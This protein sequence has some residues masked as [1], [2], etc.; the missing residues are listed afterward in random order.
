MASGQHTATSSALVLEAQARTPPESPAPLL[1]TIF[2]VSVAVLLLTA[3]VLKAHQAFLEGGASSLDRAIPFGLALLEG[4]LGVMLLLNILRR[5]VWYV[6]I[7][8]F[9]AFFVISIQKVI[10]GSNSCGCFG[11]VPAPPWLIA[12]VDFVVVI[13]FF[14][15]GRGASDIGPTHR[16][17]EV[18]VAV[19][20][21]VFFA[22][23]AMTFRGPNAGNDVVV[24]KPKE[25]LGKKFPLLS[26]TDLAHEISN[27]N[28]TIVL[29]HSNCAACERVVTEY[30]RAVS[31]TA[32]MSKRV[33]VLEFPPFDSSATPRHAGSGLFYG[34]VSGANEWFVATPVVIETRSAIVTAVT[35][36]PVNLP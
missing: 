27:G 2:R 3:A 16:I 29:F 12:V 5:F 10:E 17:R 34:R 33:A 15:F 1:P 4:A 31:S 25:W 13:G 36:P 18:V 23:M 24:L 8:V 11:V 6:G 7:C 22:F 28:W 21:I 9:I 32:G 30:Q 19:I 20:A 14:A 26:H 35:E